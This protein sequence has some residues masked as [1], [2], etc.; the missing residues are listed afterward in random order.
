MLSF[1]GCGL[2]SWAELV[3]VCHKTRHLVSGGERSD[4]R[5]GNY[6]CHMQTVYLS[7]KIQVES[8]EALGR[9]TPRCCRI[10]TRR[11]CFFRDCSVTA[12]GPACLGLRRSPP[13]HERQRLSRVICGGIK[14]IAAGSQGGAAEKP[15]TA[16]S[17]QKPSPASGN[18]NILQKSFT[19]IL[20][21]VSAHEE[22]GRASGDRLTSRVGNVYTC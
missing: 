11:G 7:V 12:V 21:F 6:I 15:V 18:G 8:E 4:C 22:F 10:N 19:N 3:A 13:G 14:A 17:D 2:C 20:V 9:E 5:V 1:T 16:G